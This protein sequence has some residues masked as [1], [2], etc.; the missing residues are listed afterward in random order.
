MRTLPFFSNV[1]VALLRAVCRLPVATKV[2]GGA[3]VG[4][5]VGVGMAV[6]L[7]IADAVAL[8]GAEGVALGT[9]GV[10][11]QPRNPMS[12][13]TAIASRH[14]DPLTNFPMP[15]SPLR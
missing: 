4:E 13:T 15:I 7:T 12:A 3:G 6:G 9:L 11:E 5:G 14:A 1:A 10:L 2:S 8:G